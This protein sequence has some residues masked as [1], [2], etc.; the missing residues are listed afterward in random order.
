MSLHSDIFI[1]GITLDPPSLRLQFAFQVKGSKLA[2]HKNNFLPFLFQLMCRFVMER[3]KYHASDIW[4]LDPVRKTKRKV[5]V[6][7][8]RMHEL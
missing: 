8:F 3:P 6:G 5:E 7:N 4:K 1:Q 2:G